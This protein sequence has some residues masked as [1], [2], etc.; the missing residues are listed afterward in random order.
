MKPYK[1]KNKYK[2]RVKKK[3]K[4]DKKLNQRGEKTIK[5]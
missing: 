4:C 2:T 1:L 3:K 5:C